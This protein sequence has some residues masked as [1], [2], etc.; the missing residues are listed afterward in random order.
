VSAFAIAPSDPSR[1]YAATSFSRLFYSSNAGASWTQSGFSTPAPHYLTG[2]AIVVSPS[3]S[4]DVWVGGSGY[5]NPAVFASTDGGQ[6]FAPFATGLP[7]TL[8]YDLA[9]GPLGAGDLYAATE[10]G[11][12]RYDG[13]AGAWQSLLSDSAPMTIYWSVETALDRVRFGTYGRGIWDYVPPQPGCSFTTSPPDASF[14]AAGGGGV[15]NVSAQSGC[16]WSAMRLDDW[17][18]LSGATKGIG[19]GSV[20]YT[21]AANTTSS[22]RTA[23]LT[24]QGQTLTIAQAGLASPDFTLACS[25][26]GLSVA[27]GASGSSSCTVGST[28]GFS[29][30]VSLSCIGLPAGASCSYTPNPVTPP[31]NGS[32]NSS[33]SVS[34]SG[35]LP[36]GTYPF[37]AQ[38]VSGALVHAFGMA[39]QVTAGAAELVV[40]GGFEGGCT[41]WAITGTGVTCQ[42]G[43]P[44]PHGGTG[45][46]Q[47]SGNSKAGRVYQQVAIPVAAPAGLTFW[48]NVTSQETTPSAMNDKLFVE[49]RSTSN[50]LLATLGTFSNLDKS[51]P[52]SYAQKAFSLAAFR[53]QTV[54]LVFRVKTNAAQQTTFR[55][56]DVSLK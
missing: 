4:M 20:P 44:F 14:P 39:L 16:V 38:G 6:T 1:W 53:G 37:Q 55:V 25:P 2:L 12:Y 56:D 43:G 7:S 19:N 46:A 30:S 50:V 52:G 8:V 10:S 35:S 51:T 29:A 47:L 54:R 21:V 45:Y 22:S 28:N 48:L 5:S 36:T 33:L 42:Q 18:G 24:V 31:A 49:V 15:L 40:N 23:Y 17:I 41:P 13:G 11:P 34:A 27:Q 3:D 32:V 26:A 9:T